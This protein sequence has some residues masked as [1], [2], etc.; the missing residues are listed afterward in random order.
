MFKLSIFIIAIVMFVVSEAVEAVDEDQCIQP[1]SLISFDRFGKDSLLLAFN[2]KQSNQT[3]Y[4]YQK[5]RQ[6]FTNKNRNIYFSLFDP[7]INQT[8]NTFTI[9][10]YPHILCVNKAQEWGT[11]INYVSGMFAQIFVDCDNDVLIQVT[12]FSSQFENQDGVDW[13]PVI[14][15]GIG[16]CLLICVCVVLC[17]FACKSTVDFLVKRNENNEKRSL[18]GQYFSKTYST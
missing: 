8:N 9:C 18:F 6:D 13:T 10:I 5:Q 3:L 17:S 4:F 12:T 7:K 16:S 2:Q 1:P 14:L 15:I 11:K